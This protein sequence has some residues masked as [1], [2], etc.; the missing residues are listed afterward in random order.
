[1]AILLLS[2]GPAPQSS[3]HPPGTDISATL[4]LSQVFILEAAGA[5]PDDT[6][7]SVA[8]GQRRVVVLRRSAPDFGLFATL[9]FGD[10]SLRSPRGSDS[11]RVM[12]HPLPGEYAIDLEVAGTI[13]NGASVVFSY[14]SHFVAPAG[15]RQR[16]GSDLHFERELRVGRLEDG[17]QVRLLPTWRPG[18]DMVGAELVGPG[19]GRYLVVAPR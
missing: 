4:P 6:S 1:M 16:Y 18:T 2:C 17:N 12:I 14:G 8:S 3:A 11:A 19:P 13:G 9:E 15:A 7:L 5:M 10:S